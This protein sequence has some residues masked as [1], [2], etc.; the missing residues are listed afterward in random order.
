MM[1]SRFYDKPALRWLFKYVVRAI[2]VPDKTLKQDVPDEIREAI[3]ALDRGECVVIFPEGFLRRSDD[4]PLK[5]FGRGVWQILSARPKTPVFTCWI[6]G[7]WGSFCSY[8][9][10]KPTKNKRPDFRRPIGVAVAAPI[11]LGPETLANHLQSRIA[12]MNHVL[13]ARKLLGLPQ[14]APVELPHGESDPEHPS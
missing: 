3:A 12:L 9:N 8:F 4:K 7:N 14:L 13:E 10:G 1:T 6:E 2:R 11:L 5:R